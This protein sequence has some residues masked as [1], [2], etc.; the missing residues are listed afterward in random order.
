M[1]PVEADGAGIDEMVR[2]TYRPS[3]VGSRTRWPPIRREHAGRRMRAVAEAP[4]P[5]LDPEELGTPGML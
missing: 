3:L 5:E 2:D 1:E 4:E